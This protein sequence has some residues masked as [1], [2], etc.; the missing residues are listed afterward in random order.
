MGYNFSWNRYKSTLLG[1]RKVQEIKKIGYLKGHNI[2]RYTYIYIYKE[3]C[4]CSI[5]NISI[6]I[7]IGV[8]VH[9]HGNFFSQLFIYLLKRAL[10]L[11]LKLLKRACDPI[12]NNYKDLSVQKAFKNLFGSS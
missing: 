11:I 5:K 12:E 9:M 10:G 1:S 8:C 3:A 4:E 6:Y 7:C 2:H